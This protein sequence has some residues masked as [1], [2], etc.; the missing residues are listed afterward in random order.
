MEYK[1]DAFIVLPVDNH[2]PFPTMD[3]IPSTANSCRF[4]YLTNY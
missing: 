3:E 2:V 1:L 4:V